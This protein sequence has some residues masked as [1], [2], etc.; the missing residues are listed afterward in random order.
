MDRLGESSRLPAIRR[1]PNGGVNSLIV[2]YFRTIAEDSNDVN[3]LRG[4][5]LICHL[6]HLTLMLR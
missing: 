4:R 3:H 2:Q 6:A 5:A 1:A